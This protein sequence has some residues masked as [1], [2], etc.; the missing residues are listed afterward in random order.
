LIKCINF[1]QSLPQAVKL[2]AVTTLLILSFVLCIF[3]SASS[4]ETA[5]RFADP[6]LE[7]VVRQAISKPKGDFLPSELAK[8]IT[9][10][11][12]MRLIKYRN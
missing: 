2:G 3:Q 11:A 7:A 6:E 4:Q 5:V 12:S 8:L 1:E 10:N 9:L